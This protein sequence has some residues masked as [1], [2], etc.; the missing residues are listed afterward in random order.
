MRVCVFVS[1]TRTRAY[2]SLSLLTLYANNNHFLSLLLSLSLSLSLVY[3]KFLT[4][5]RNLHSR[6]H[7]VLSFSFCFSS[8]SRSD[9]KWSTGSEPRAVSWSPAFAHHS[10]R[11]DS[12]CEVR[13]TL[14]GQSLPKE[15]EVHP[16]S[17]GV[18]WDGE[19]QPLNSED[20][21]PGLGLQ[22]SQSK[23][24][25]PPVWVPA[26]PSGLQ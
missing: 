3:P 11:N 19:A 26:S 18:T 12:S 5:N 10:H 7:C 21:T 8:S 14:A 16:G 4:Q 22:K 23:Y 20:N 6:T 17:H 2:F 24:Q 25:E 1:R 15:W 13:E 9:T